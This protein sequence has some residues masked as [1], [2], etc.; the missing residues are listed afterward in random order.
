M[1]KPP[2]G[3]E[4]T[5]RPSFA[6]R[7]ARVVQFLAA[8]VVLAAAGFGLRGRVFRPVPAPQ[9]AAPAPPPAPAPVPASS[10]AVTP[11]ASA[12]PNPAPVRVP[13]PPAPPVSGASPQ[14]AASPASPPIGDL[15][16]S[17]CIPPGQEDRLACRSK[18]EYSGPTWRK[19][20][21]AQPSSA[22]DSMQ[23][24]LFGSML[25]LFSA[26]TPGDGGCGERGHLYEFVNQGDSAVPAL[27]LAD[28]EG[29]QKH[30]PSL[31][32]GESCLIHSATIL[33]ATDGSLGGP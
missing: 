20:Q 7:G 24:I 12:V 4:Y 30:V 28:R 15:S 21:L 11:A 8:V 33:H 25:S 18:I 29:R 5:P 17:G 13:L 14:Q 2:K 3:F 1:G 10:P 6:S 32:P 9:A 23:P 19:R 22:L 26:I 16:S 31:L 27:T